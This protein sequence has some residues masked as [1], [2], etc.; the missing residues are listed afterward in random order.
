LASEGIAQRLVVR[1]PDKAPLLNGAVAV[2]ASSYGNALAMA[3]ALKGAT[4]L[5]FVSGR[6]TEDRLQQHLA[7]V[8]A[9]HEAGVERIVYLSFLG[10]APIATFTLARQHFATE[11]QIQDSGATFTFLRSSL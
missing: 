1:D 4:T 11:E 3:S 6:E 7:A 5:F 10:A 2:G 8:D 9:A